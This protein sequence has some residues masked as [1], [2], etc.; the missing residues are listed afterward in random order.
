MLFGSGIEC[1]ILIQVILQRNY[2]QEQ[3]Q[4]TWILIGL[5]YGV[6][7]FMFLILNYKMERNFLN[8]KKRST[9]GIFMGFSRT[10]S[11]TISLA[12]NINTGSVTPQFHVIHDELFTTIHNF[13]THNLE[14]LYDKLSI[15][16]CHNDYE[17]DIDDFGKDIPALSVS[18]EWINTDEMKLRREQERLRFRRLYGRESHSISHNDL[19]EPLSISSPSS[20]VPDLHVQSHLRTSVYFF[21]FLF[22]S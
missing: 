17:P 5:V 20:S 19:I 10:H 7:L 6:A 15:I 14:E 11:S 22:S 9:T 13:G 2:S 18:I 21:S 12:L 1:Q 8:G 16:S 4:H 3:N